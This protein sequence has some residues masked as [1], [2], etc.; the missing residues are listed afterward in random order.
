MSSGDAAEATKKRSRRTTLRE[1][2]GS[3][4]ISIEMGSS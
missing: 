1:S 4:R 2:L 3:R